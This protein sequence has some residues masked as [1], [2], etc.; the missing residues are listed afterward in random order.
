[1]RAQVEERTPFPWSVKEPLLKETN[2]KCAHCGTP[3]DRYTNLSVDHFIP[4]SKGGSNDP[5]NLTVLCDDCNT[6]KS[7]MILPA[8]GWYP[9]LAPS[10]KK[11]LN[12][13]LKRYMKET[14]YLAEDCLVPMDTFRIEAPVTTRKKFGNGGYREIRMPVYIRGT[15]MERDDAFAWLMEY[16]R[17]LKYRDACGVMES[18]TEFNAPCYILKKG[19][20]EIAMVNPWMIHDWDEE[21]KNWRNEIV[22][23]WFFIQDLPKRDYLPEMLQWVVEGVEMYIARSISSTTDGACAVLFRTRCFLSDRFCAPVFDRMTK[24]RRDELVEFDTGHSLT[25]QI[26]ELSRI[27]IMGDPKACKELTKRLELENPDKWISMEDVANENNDF[28]KRFE[29][30]GE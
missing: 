17:H 2:G 19:D 28:N 4:L 7:N 13:N 25:G 12:E 11:I 18:P 24:G 22:M 15:R 6:L 3:L 27:N 8:V 20:I 1:M 10:K 29:G 9:Y 30:K 16:K 23:D 14:D 21:M 26:R 5:E